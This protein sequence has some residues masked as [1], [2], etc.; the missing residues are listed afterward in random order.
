[1]KY[2]EKCNVSI[3]GN[4]TRCPLCQNSLRGDAQPAIYPDIPGIHKKFAM[5]F[6]I[7]TLSAIFAI[8][9]CM[10]IDIA[11]NSHAHWSIFA[12]FGIFCSWLSMCVAIKKRRTIP[13]NITY[14]AVLISVLSV[15]WDYF[16][17]FRGWSLDFVI[18]ITC[19]AATISS[20]ILEIIME[21]SKDRFILCVGLNILFGFVPLI[22]YHTNNLRVFI[23]SIICIS[24]SILS[25]SILLLFKGKFIAQELKKHFH[26]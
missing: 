9:V 15:L 8:V 2:C 19:A 18:P 17:G 6:K 1:M 10:S 26:I 23:P 21:M 3:R 14:Q 11:I 4:L 25:M 7:S 5:F 16:T 12:A 20:V 22:F 24:V 13:K